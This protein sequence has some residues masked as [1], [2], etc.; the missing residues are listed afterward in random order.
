MRRPMTSTIGVM[1]L[2]VQL[3]QEMMAELSLALFAP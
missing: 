3:A 2:V 1:Q